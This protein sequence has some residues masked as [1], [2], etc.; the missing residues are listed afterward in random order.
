MAAHIIDSDYPVEYY[1]AATTE[2]DNSDD[3]QK[4]LKPRMKLALAPTHSGYIIVVFPCEQIWLSAEIDL[5]QRRIIL[6]LDDP[7]AADWSDIFARHSLNIISAL[8]SLIPAQVVMSEK[9]WTCREEPLFMLEQTEESDQNVTYYWKSFV[10]HC[11]SHIMRVLNLKSIF[12]QHLLVQFG[13]SYMP[14][15]VA[16]KKIPSLTA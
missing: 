10:R 2:P 7:R 6:K 16:N 11:S 4:L 12:N 3:W 5:L 15:I 8:N 14:W 13:K 9:P 1:I